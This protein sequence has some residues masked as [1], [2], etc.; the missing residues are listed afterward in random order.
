M[1]M[2]W[3]ELERE[4]IRSRVKDGLSRAVHEG[5]RLG[6]PR[7][8][9]GRERAIQAVQEHGGITAAAAALG[10]SESTLR[11]RLSKTQVITHDAR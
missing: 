4:T 10:V 9:L 1:S 3:A 11:R 2:V 5:K 6:R 7:R 8:R